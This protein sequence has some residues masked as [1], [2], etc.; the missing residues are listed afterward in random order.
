MD[1]PY[2]TGAANAPWLQPGGSQPSPMFDPRTQYPWMPMPWT[3]ERMPHLPERV[4]LGAEC[5]SLRR[6]TALDANRMYQ[7]LLSQSW[8]LSDAVPMAVA[9]YHQGFQMQARAVLRVYGGTYGVEAF[10]R[11]IDAVYGAP[12]P[13]QPPARV[14]QRP[15]SGAPDWAVH[16]TGLG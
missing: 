16:R 7:R 15:P 3:R 8:P 11:Q 12:E 13:A 14:G 4:C 2:N 6:L 5:W 10:N 1:I 9:L